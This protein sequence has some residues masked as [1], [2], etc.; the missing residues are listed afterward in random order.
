MFDLMGLDL[1]LVRSLL[2]VSSEVSL[3]IP[4]GGVFQR[5]GAVTQKALSLR[6]CS[7]VL[8]MEFWYVPDE[9]S[10]RDWV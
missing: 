7:L 3:W 1:E 6:V 9:C 8:G 5:V 4:A 10:V 2:K